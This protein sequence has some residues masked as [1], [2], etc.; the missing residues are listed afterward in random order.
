[1]SQAN[2]NMTGTT[3]GTF[4]SQTLEDIT[5]IHKQSAQQQLNPIFIFGD[6]FTGLKMLFIVVTGQA[7]GDAL[8]TSGIPGVDWHAQLLIM[9]I[10]TASSFFLW[11]HIITGRDV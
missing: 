4:T 1:M 11:F 5:N 10:F 3:K 2:T 8:I 9:I 7:I 6:F